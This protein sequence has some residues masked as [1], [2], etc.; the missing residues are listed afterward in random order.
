MSINFKKNYCFLIC[1]I[2]LPVFLPAQYTTQPKLPDGVLTPGEV[3]KNLVGKVVTVQGMVVKFEPTWNERYPNTV[4]LR[5]AAG[6]SLRALYWKNIEGALGPEQTP[7]PGQLLRVKGQINEFRGDI[8]LSITAPGDI[9][10]VG[11]EMEV[12]IPVTPLNAISKDKLNQIVLIQGKVLSIRPSWKPTAPDIVT[13]SDDEDVH[14]S[15]VYWSD[16]KERLQPQD[17]PEVGKIFQV[18]GWVDIYRDQIQVKVD[19]PYKL[20]RIGGSPAPQV[21]AVTP[22]AAAGDAPAAATG[23]SSNNSLIAALNPGSGIQSTQPVQETSV[24]KT[25]SPNAATNPL[26]HPAADSGTNTGGKTSSPKPVFGYN[27][28]FA[29]PPQNASSATAQKQTP[30]PL[31]GNPLSVPSA[32]VSQPLSNQRENP[33]SDLTGDRPFVR[34]TPQPQAPKGPGFYIIDKARAVI[35]GPPPRPHVLFF[36]SQDHD[37]YSNDPL[38]LEFSA[39]VVFVWIDINES[40][41]IAQQLGVKSDPTWIYYG[42]DGFE[43]ARNVGQLSSVQLIQSLTPLLH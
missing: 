34:Q 35:Q 19:N 13:L 37:P 10:D 38:F 1:I 40:A 15:V 39:K 21:A 12:K 27:N 41:H 9:V 20:K 2:L 31:N 3:T 6:N 43:K 28:P 26:S 22:D 18:E 36:T 11:S 17:I 23:A 29:P 24:N 25:A 16:V 7:K 4:Y 33:A 5:D 30:T 42:A 32:P 14:V 8:N